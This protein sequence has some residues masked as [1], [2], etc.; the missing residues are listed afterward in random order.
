MRK[1]I[2]SPVRIGVLFLLALLGV[3]VYAYDAYDAWQRGDFAQRTLASYLGVERLPASAHDIEC[4]E[5]ADR[6]EPDNPSTMCFVRIEP[7]DFDLLARQARLRKNEKS[8]PENFSHTHQMGLTIG[9]SFKINEEHWGGSEGFRADLYPDA[10]HSQ[11]VAVL[12]RPRKS[13]LICD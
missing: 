4:M 5:I 9:P 1:K 6:C 3:A 12:S 7:A 10:A 2:A 13:P 11:F 8:C